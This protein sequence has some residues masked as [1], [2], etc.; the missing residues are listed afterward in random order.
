M[1]TDSEV[2]LG[3][4]YLALTFRGLI[5]YLLPFVKVLFGLAGRVLLVTWFK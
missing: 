4:A 2:F 1:R 5:E 3:R